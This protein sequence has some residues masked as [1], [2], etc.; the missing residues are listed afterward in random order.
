MNMEPRVKRLF[1]H[2]EEEGDVPDAIVL[3]NGTDPMLDMTFFYVTRLKVGAFEGGVAVLR[4]DGSVSVVTSLLEAETASKGDFELHVFKTHDERKEMVAQL[5]KGA[6][7][8]GV[9]AG[10]LTHSNY[11]FINDMA[12]DGAGTMDVSKFITRTRSVKD[13][14]EIAIIRKACQICS[15][16]VEEIVPFIKEGVVEYEISAELCYI[17]QKKGA[18]GPAFDTIVAFGKNSAEPHYIAGNSKLAR[19]DFVLMDFGALYKRYRSDITRTYF[20]GEPSEKQRRMYEVVAEAQRRGLNAI[21]AGVKASEPHIAAAEYIDSTEF[22]GL[23]THGLGH[24]L[25]LATH[26]GGGLN[27]R[28]ENVVLEEGMVLTVE[29]GVYVPGLG[30]VR[31]EDDIVVRKDGPEIL[32][33]AS[34]DII[35]V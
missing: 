3:V 27:P 35:V 16:A 17:M 14:E 26:D 7:L 9:N 25:G 8:V 32:T 34:R 20:C 19:G 15:E 21:R 18:T 10:E 31:I 12:Q 23:F 28:A 6:E 5:L 22:K 4:Q 2:I 24:G 29:P 33:G 11:N 1:K 30:G 13:D